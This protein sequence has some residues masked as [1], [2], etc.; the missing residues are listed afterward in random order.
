VHVAF[1]LAAF[2]VFDK[3]NVGVINDERDYDLGKTGRG[4]NH[5]G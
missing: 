5:E 2:Y 3:N 1:V 4:N